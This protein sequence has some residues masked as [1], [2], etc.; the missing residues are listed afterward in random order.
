[1]GVSRRSLIKMSWWEACDTDRTLSF[2]KITKQPVESDDWCTIREQICSNWF[3]RFIGEKVRFTWSDS[4]TRVGGEKKTKK[5]KQ[6][7]HSYFL[8]SNPNFRAVWWCFRMKYCKI[9][10]IYTESWIVCLIGGFQYR[11]QNISETWSHAP[12]H[13]LPLVY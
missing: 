6:P 11:T 9:I 4:F 12:I 3:N 13:R 1:M 8:K 5:T 2:L 10:F 7:K